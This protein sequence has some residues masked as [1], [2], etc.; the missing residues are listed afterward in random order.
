MTARMRR[1]AAISVLLASG[2][3]LVGC[4][5]SGH[6]LSGASS[7]RPSASSATK[8]APATKAA[9][10]GANAPRGSAATALAR[11]QA[12]AFAHAVN[13]RAGDL[14]GFRPSSADEHHGAG[15]KRLERELFRCVG[16]TGAG[17]QLVESSSGDFE[18]HASILSL[19]LSSEVNV[20]PTPALA[21]KEL[22]AFHSGVLPKC[23]SHYFS[24]LLDSQS[25]RGA[26]VSPV[27]TKQG[28]PP[29]AGAT[30]S[31]GLRFT[32]TVTLHHIPI[33]LYIDILGF[34]KG[35]AEIS[36]FAT[37]LPEPVPAKIEEHLFTLLLERAKTHKI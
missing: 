35:S 13:L 31:F 7:T 37:G 19:T 16:S 2:G 18:H 15:E 34:V 23:L 6:T 26:R 22:T 29:A 32:A 28:S 3:L 11:A 8:T 36:L 10:A 25:F 4:G 5:G 1:T 24:G 33:P 12:R 14:P 27:S 9:H 17:D 30:G 21:A 20:A